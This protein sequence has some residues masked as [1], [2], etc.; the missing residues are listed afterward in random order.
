MNDIGRAG[1]CKGISERCRE[2]GS[3]RDISISSFNAGFLGLP[4]FQ[5]PPRG[6]EGS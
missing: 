1:Y 4:D 6:G 5:L 2:A 3:S